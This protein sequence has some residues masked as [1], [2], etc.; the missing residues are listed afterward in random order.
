MIIIFCAY[1]LEFKDSDCV[2]HDWFTLAPELELAYRTSIH[3]STCKPAEMLEKGWNHKLPVNTL[4]K[5]LVDIHPTTS[6]FKL[7]N[8][9]VK[10]HVS[11]NMTD[12]FE[13]SEQKWDKSHKT[14]EFKV[15]D[16]ILVSKMTFNN[17]KGPNKLRYSFS[18]PFI[19][20]SLHGEN[21]VQVEL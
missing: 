17:I 5:E 20:K 13:Y 14:P 3:A 16:L 12:A 6:G 18:G 9:K 8:D 19:I 4:S 1:G 15:G 2:T 11:K 21:A 7:L 10:Q